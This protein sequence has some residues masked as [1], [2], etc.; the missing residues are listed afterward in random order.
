[1][2]IAQLT[3]PDT[4]AWLAPM[5]GVTDDVYRTICHELGAVASVT[6]M[7]SAKSLYYGG[8][9][10]ALAQKNAEYSVCGVQIFGSD[11]QIMAWAA[12]RLEALAFDFIDINFGCPVAKV[13]KNAEGSALMQNIPL[14]M[15]IIKEVR[16]A[17]YKPLT[18][19]IRKGWDADTYLQFALLAQE[20]GADAVCLHA[21]TREQFYSGT[22][23][24]NA[25]RVL[26]QN[27]K[28]P[29]IGNGDIKTQ[30][31]ALAMKAATGCDAVMIGRAAEGNPWIFD[32]V[33]CAFANED[34]RQIEPVEKIDMA[35]RHTQR[36]IECFGERSAILQM[37]K[38]VAW[39]L[40]GLPHSAEIRQKVNNCTSVD[41]FR[42][43][44]WDYVAECEFS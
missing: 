31:D 13:V 2:K 44:L 16:Q 38:H 33:R 29:V 26:K 7:I 22:A 1:M 8:D 43:I 14:A 15:Q 5:A 34:V 25:I 24:W 40:K 39:Y 32:A 28:I 12:H 23:D 17:T 36:M 20:N 10:E 35:L 21:R 42:R 6:E 18:I 19:K 11:P 30:Q 3:V 9:T 4:G 37:R 41:A 27:L